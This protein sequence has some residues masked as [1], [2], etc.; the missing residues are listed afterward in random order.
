M[1]HNGFRTHHINQE[2][3]RA[4]ESA[5]RY[6]KSGAHYEITSTAQAVIYCS[7]CS[8]PV[9]DSAISRGR[10]A[11]AKRTPGCA[12]AMSTPAQCGQPDRKE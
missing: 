2:R 4:M 11:R 5:K 7:A 1:K 10:H 9:V 12:E 3:I 8:A 6:K